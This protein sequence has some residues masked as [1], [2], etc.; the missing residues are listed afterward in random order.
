LYGGGVAIACIGNIL[1]KH[2]VQRRI[3]EGID[4]LR[5]TSSGGLDGDI[6][7]L[8]K[9][10]TSVLNGCVFG[11]TEKFFF[12]AHVASADNM[13]SVFPGTIAERLTLRPSVMGFFNP[14]TTSPTGRR[15]CAA[16]AA[17]AS[18]P[19]TET[20]SVATTGWGRRGLGAGPIIPTLKSL[21]GGKSFMMTNTTYT[22]GGW[23]GIAA[24]CEF[25]I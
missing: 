16:I 4:G 8:V 11:V 25:L 18:S 12:G 1:Q 7:V 10:D 13:L 2:R 6:V 24:R 5:H 21:S 3:G 20:S 15:E 22:T 17:A 23:G 14:V 9:V 19:V